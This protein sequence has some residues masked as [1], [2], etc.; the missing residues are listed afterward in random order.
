[1]SDRK[2]ILVNE[3]SGKQAPFWDRHFAPILALTGALIAA[4]FAISDNALNL[5]VNQ[6]PTVEIKI[7]KNN[8]E[9]GH[10]VYARGQ[11]NDPGGDPNEINY[12]WEIFELDTILLEG[13]GI[14]YDRV[15]LPTE[16]A[17][18]YTLMVTVT[19]NNGK[20]KY[21]RNEAIFIV[22]DAEETQ[23]TVVL[24]QPVS[25]PTPKVAQSIE[26]F[27]EIVLTE[28]TEIDWDKTQASRIITNGYSLAI[29]G[30]SI[31]SDLSILSFS[32]NTTKGK[33]GT[34]GSPGANG[35]REQKV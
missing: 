28:K 27:P 7:S 1:V 26:Y 11:V 20:G 19:D 18:T 12:R 3:T 17:G 16:K 10:R 22:V 33:D 2:I 32:G 30:K 15:D 5:I 6:P 25:S 13:V 29:T 8:A 31:D 24:D 14:E 34:S 23:N 4:F 21:A 9:V 35:G